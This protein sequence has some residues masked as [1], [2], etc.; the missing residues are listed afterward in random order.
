[1]RAQA[2][3]AAKLTRVEREGPLSQVWEILV[4]P[5][6]PEFGN[7]IPGLAKLQPEFAEDYL[8]SDQFRYASSSDA[9]TLV[10]F[11]PET[12]SVRV[13]F[14]DAETGQAVYDETLSRST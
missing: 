4:G 13:R 14:L 9:A 10:T 3:P 1:M 2:R 8:P 11:D 12:D 7:P 6:A 5:G